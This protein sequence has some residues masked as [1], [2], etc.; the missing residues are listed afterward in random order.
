[1]NGCPLG[2]FQEGCPSIELFSLSSHPKCF[3]VS[4]RTETGGMSQ[5]VAWGEMCLGF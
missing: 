2:T 4:A 3:F 5:Q 1:M